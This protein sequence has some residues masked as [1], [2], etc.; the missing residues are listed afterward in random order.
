MIQDTFTHGG[1]LETEP[2]VVSK[3]T[4]LVQYFAQ[5][6]W[7]TSLKSAIY[8]FYVDFSVEEG[9][10]CVFLLILEDKSPLLCQLGT[11]CKD[12]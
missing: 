1:V 11:R 10:R 8:Y 9:K 4:F 12:I 6:G 7:L 2:E 3:A 5:N